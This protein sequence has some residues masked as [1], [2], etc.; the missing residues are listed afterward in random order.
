MNNNGIA[1]TLSLAVLL[2]T[3]PALGEGDQ[4][5][6]KYHFD[7]GVKLFNKSDFSGALAEFMKAHAEKPH[8][9]VLYNIAKCEMQLE[10]Y[11]SALENFEKYLDEAGG[12][13]DTKRLEEVNG[14]IS[15]L[16]DS[17]SKLKVEVQQVGA[18]ILIDGKEM[19]TTPLAGLIFLNAGTHNL[20]IE[21]EGYQD[22]TE[23][24]ILSRSESATFK[25]KL[26]QAEGSPVL[27]DPVVD[28]PVVDQPAVDVPAK[29]DKKTLGVLPFA[30]TMSVGGALLAGSLGTF[31][32]L[33]SAR[34]DYGWCYADDPSCYQPTERDIEKLALATDILW[35]AGA[36]V[37]TAALV[38]IAFTKFPK[39]E[40]KPDVALG[41]LLGPD[42][43]GLI[44]QGRF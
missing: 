15:E 38:L 10:D 9:S 29:A 13:L 18:V 39:K 22:Y 26:E 19:G 24:F 23:E 33:L 14:Y 3:A 40:K 31:I 36:A 27:D 17:L 30:I 34:S 28:Q 5:T 11:L 37:T 2:L 35:I 4:D 12:T 6:A 21:K 25:I 8:Y 20:R 43:A 16:E 44:L 7:Q 32:G 42:N 41:P 1:A